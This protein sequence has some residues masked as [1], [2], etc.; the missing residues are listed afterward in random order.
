MASVNKVIAAVDREA[1]EFLEIPEVVAG[2]P[3]Q[4]GM[5]PPPPSLSLDR[6][7]TI[8]LMLK[9]GPD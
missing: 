4:E 3:V 1:G 5:I 7:L 9:S 8:V 2:I 6:F